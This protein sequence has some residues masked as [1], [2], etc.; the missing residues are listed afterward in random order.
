[1]PR[2]RQWAAAG[3]VDLGRVEVE[4]EPLRLVDELTLGERRS[5]AL[6]A[7]RRELR[8]EARDRAEVLGPKRVPAASV[9][10]RIPAEDGRDV[11]ILELQRI[12][13]GDPDPR[14]ARCLDRGERHDVV[15]DDH[16]RLELVEDL[17]E[18][19]VHVAGAVAE[20][21]P[22]RLYELGE[23]VIGRLAE[24]RGRVPDEV[25][26]ELPRLLLDFGRRAE[27]H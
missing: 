18:A 5:A 12:A 11:G 10:F 19:I 1:V 24:D 20:R 15:L 23:L 13:G 6:G 2:R 8:V 7:E 25:L 27:P 26:P 3:V 4:V 17:A 14:P 16:V 9:G 22:R 21:A